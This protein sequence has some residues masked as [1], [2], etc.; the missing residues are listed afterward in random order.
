MGGALQP[1]ASKGVP[2]VGGVGRA[3][4]GW[5]HSQRDASRMRLLGP[6]C[7]LLGRVASGTPLRVR[8]RSQ[9]LTSRDLASRN[10]LDAGRDRFCVAST[11]KSPFWAGNKAASEV[12]AHP[13]KDASREHSSRGLLGVV[14][15]TPGGGLEEL[16]CTRGKC[17]LWWIS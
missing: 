16:M 11:S 6:G 8:T 14:G 9:G 4:S 15:D 2:G 5:G 17:R 13:E 10:P 12:G 1:P 3:D 7:L